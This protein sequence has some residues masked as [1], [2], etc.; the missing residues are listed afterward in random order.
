MF[1]KILFIFIS[2]F[3]ELEA[4]QDILSF[5]G[6]SI[7]NC[8]QNISNSKTEDIV[9]NCNQ[10]IDKL[11]VYIEFDKSKKKDK[12]RI[13]KTLEELKKITFIQQSSYFKKK[14]KRL[15]E[16]EKS[17]NRIINDKY[18]QQRVSLSYMPID[19]FVFYNKKYIDIAYEYELLK[20][21]NYDTLFSIESFLGINITESEYSILGKNNSLENKN[22][23]IGLGINKYIAKIFKLSGR[24]GI[25]S[26]SY[27]F[28]DF[29]QWESTK[30][31]PF[32]MLSISTENNIFEKVSFNLGYR[33]IRHLPIQEVKFNPI[34]ESSSNYQTINTQ[35]VFFR[36]GYKWG[37]Y[38]NE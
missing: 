31:K 27:K 19:E 21:S 9:M 28:T 15:E 34:G 5:G 24:V 11:E 36:I 8:R 20:D 26:T 4:H 14:L 7:Q 35:G 1:R 3:I 2:T 6:D 32:A 17:V 30:H 29:E 10:Y 33:W 23:I 38:S 18:N 22:L 13:E 25:R 12:K 16:L 37:K